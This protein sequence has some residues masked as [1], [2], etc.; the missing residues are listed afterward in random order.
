M[1]I[2]FYIPSGLAPGATVELPEA[3]AHHACRVLRLSEGDAVT[4]FDGQG[5]EWPAHLLKAGRVRVEGYRAVDCESPLDVSLI[6]ALPAADKMD[7]IVQKCVELGVRR[8]QPV[9]A[10]RSIIRLSGERMARRIAHWQAVAVAACEQC[11]RNR[12]PEVA[13]LLDLPQALA[14]TAARNEVRWLLV[15]EGTSRLREQ[16]P[17]SQPVS[18]LVGPEGG[19]EEVEALAAASAGFTGLTL[20][21]RILRTETAGAAALA[22]MQTLWGDW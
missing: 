4:L 21:P 16:P 11:G 18:L 1:K 22:A 12:V 7:F 3:A 6:Q 14:Q 19:F 8:I 5:G 17:P 15:P 20:G 2:R 13:D 9:V 10:R